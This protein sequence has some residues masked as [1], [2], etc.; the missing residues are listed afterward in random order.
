MLTFVGLP[1]LASSGVVGDKEY[2]SLHF[3]GAEKYAD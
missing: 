1:T 3:L 2:V